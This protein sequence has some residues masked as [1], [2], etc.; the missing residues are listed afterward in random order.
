[1]TRR[2]ATRRRKQANLVYRAFRWRGDALGMHEQV[3]CVRFIRLYSDRQL[4][5]LCIFKTGF[6][7]IL[8]PTAS[9]TQIGS[10]HFDC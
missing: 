7:C 6:S 4:S 5:K 3:Q 1:M 8:V 10:I 2:K 9:L